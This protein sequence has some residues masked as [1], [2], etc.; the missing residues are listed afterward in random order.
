MNSSQII[1]YILHITILCHQLPGRC[2]L[3]TANLL[4]LHSIRRKQSIFSSY[5]TSH[6]Q[7]SKL[8]IT[9]CCTILGYTLQVWDNASSPILRW[10]KHKLSSHSNGHTP[11]LFSLI[12]KPVW[13]VEGCILDNIFFRI[14]GFLMR[15]YF[16]ISLHINIYAPFT[17][18]FS[19]TFWTITLKI[20]YIFRLQYYA[21]ITH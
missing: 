5:R 13:I 11:L 4:Q 16:L 12:W 9:N 7:H 19:I 3:F 21:L 18:T 20:T 14:A 17:A 1:R 2:I 10:M 8:I 6:R 15:W